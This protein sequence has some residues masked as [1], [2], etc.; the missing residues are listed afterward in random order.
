MELPTKSSNMDNNDADGAVNSAY[1]FIEL[2]RYAYVTGDTTEF[3]AMSE[4]D[5][6]FCNSEG[7]LP[8]VRPAERYPSPDTACRWSPA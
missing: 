6:I 2:Y 7:R 5:C 4:D 8:H 1:Y 3:A